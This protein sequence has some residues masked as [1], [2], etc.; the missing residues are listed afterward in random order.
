MITSM[1][2]EN[3]N[4]NPRF[5]SDMMKGKIWKICMLFEYYMSIKNICKIGIFQSLYIVLLLCRIYQGFQDFVKKKLNF[6]GFSEICPKSPKKII[7]RTRK[8]QGKF[9]RKIQNSCIPQIFLTKL[10]K[11]CNK[12]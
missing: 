3:V 8:I 2:N 10:L 4:I 12:K 7:F 1:I 5:Y 11:H 9:P 6:V